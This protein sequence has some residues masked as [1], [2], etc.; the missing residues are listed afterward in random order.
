MTILPT[1]GQPLG[2]RVSAT[3]LPTPALWFRLLAQD[4]AALR[5]AR[6]GQLDLPYASAEWCRWDLFPAADPNRP[7]LILLHGAESPDREWRGGSPRE[8]SALAEGLRAHGWAAALPGRGLAPAVTPSR[9]VH[10][11]HKA[12][13]WLAAQGPRHGIAGPLVVAGWG[14]GA[15][16]A[17]LALDHPHVVAGMGICGAYELDA[18]GADATE[19]EVAVLSP[20][21]LPVVRKP[22]VLAHEGAEA[23]AASAA[24]HAAR[25]AG[26]GSGRLIALPGQGTTRLLD[27]LRAPDGALCRAVLELAG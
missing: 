1:S 26:G 20:L 24:F 23:A 7:C 9:I 25:Q 16:L 2:S 10:E 18:D 27:E 19:L 17:A 4:S 21:H 6:P 5:Q 15:H 8:C 22:F 13:G 14:A 11:T 3:R 12:L